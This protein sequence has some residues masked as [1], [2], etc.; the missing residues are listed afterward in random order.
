MRQF[1]GTDGVRGIANKYPM[2][3]DTALKLGQAAAVIFS[4][5][6]RHGRFLIGKDTRLSC[7]MFENA[8]AAGIMSMGA[9]VIFVGPLP[10]PAIAHL[11]TSMRA[12]A[13]I[14]ISASH[15]P[16]NHNGIKFFA[17]N[18]YKLPDE[19]E[20]EI[21]KLMLSEKLNDY[22]A[23]NEKIGRSKRIEDASG[24]YITFSKNT[25][26]QNLTLDGMRLV[27]DCANGASYKVAPLIFE[28]LGAEVF[29]VGVSPN[30]LN[31]NSHCGA[32]YPEYASEEVHKYRADM[33]IALDG[34]ADR[35]IFIDEKGEIVDGDAILYLIAAHMMK[36]GKLKDNTLVT[37]IMSN[38]GLDKGIEKLGGKVVRT[39]VG[40]RYVVNSML[41]NHYNL[42]GEQ[43]GH[44]IFL[45]HTTTGDGIVAALQV[46]SII[47]ETGKTLS[48]LTKDMKKIPQILTNI[49]IKSKPKL[50]DISELQKVLKD[51]RKKLGKSGRLFVRYSGTEMKARILIETE[52]KNLA[53]KLTDEISDILKMHC[54]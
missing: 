38:I 28:E 8:I 13:G 16:F 46:L 29:P 42:G 25:F 19:I 37:T 53:Q 33:G 7:Y 23:L 21:E 10:T 50:E 6:H 31:I 12:D 35:V 5:K 40:D 15:N 22:L 49:N 44:I 20:L 14:V 48:E 34:D 54:V 27:V 4:K 3:V 2:T 32:L 17:S 18:G 45:D 39:A 30:G 41:K 11:T 9:D 52:D 51:G 26:P 47:K 43:S 24:R 36:K 1:F